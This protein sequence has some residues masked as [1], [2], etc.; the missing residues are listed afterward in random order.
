MGETAVGKLPGKGLRIALAVSVALN[1]AVVGVFAGSF[2]KDHEEGGPR[3]VREIG[4]GPFTEALS[5]EDRKALRK[6]VLA[7]MPGIRQARQEAG[8]DARNLLGVLRAEPFDPAQLAAL[9]EAQRVR[10]AGRFEVGQ[11]VMRD[12]L[13]AMTPE[14]RLAFADRLEQRLQ[15][16]GKGRGDK[17]ETDGPPPKP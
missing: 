15:H 12:L 13:V 1:L 11:E 3:G 4:F 17:P 5:R 7:R 9:L 2:L 16:G 8:Q 10:M 6:A 14:A